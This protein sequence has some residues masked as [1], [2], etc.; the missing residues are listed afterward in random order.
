MLVAIDTNDYAEYRKDKI[1][2]HE[3]PAAPELWAR[4]TL[5][6]K[7]AQRGLRLT[8]EVIHLDNLALMNVE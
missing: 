7:A 6:E 2:L 1:S 8:G 3:Q 4:L 5:I